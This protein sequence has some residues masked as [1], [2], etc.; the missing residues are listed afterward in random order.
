M[1]F[2]KIMIMFVL[3]IFA[4]SCVSAAENTTLDNLEMDSQI[5]MIENST[6]E[7]SQDEQIAS[8]INVTFDEKVYEKNLTD[9]TVSLPESAQGKLNVRINNHTIYDENITGR[10]VVIPIELPPVKLPVIVP[11]IW[12]AYDFTRYDVTAFY[13]GFKI[14]VTHD[15]MVMKYPKDH[16]PEFMIPSEIV[17]F[18]QH[19]SFMPA[20]LF[21]RS[22][23]GTV[24]VYLDGKILINRTNVTAPFV[25]LNET[26]ITSLDLGSHQLVADYSGDDYYNAKTITLDFNVTD[27]AISIPGNVYLDHDDCISVSVS[28][29]SKGTVAIYIDSKLVTKRSLD[30]Y[31]ELIFSL[32]DDITCGAHEI[33]VVV[34]CGTFNRTKTVNVNATYDIDL[35]SRYD[36]RYGEENT[37]YVYIPE[38][39]KEKLFNVTVNGM[40]VPFKKYTQDLEIDVSSLDVGNYT[41]VVTYLGD[42][43]YYRTTVTGNF[44]VK[45]A[46]NLH[47]HEIYFGYLTKVTLNLP[48]DAKGNLSIYIGGVLY[49]T[50]RLDK[51]KASLQISDLNPGIYDVNVTYTGDDYDVEN[52]S[53]AFI[54]YPRLKYE[55]VIEVGLKNILEFRVPKDCRG[56]IKTTIN[57]KNYTSQIRDG[58][59]TLDLSNL[60]VGDWDFDICY[61]GEDGYN[62]S[63]YA[64]VY[65]EKAPVKII[66]KSTSVGYADGVY[67][68][69]VYGNDA[70]VAKN[71]KVT[72]KIN[73]KTLKNVKTDSQGWAKVN[74]PAK[75]AVGKYTITVKCKN[76]KV[77]KS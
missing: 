46:I 4:M 47:D 10:T 71:A 29:K 60:P 20:I 11:N 57:G 77:S 74:I 42:D 45:Y 36:F 8:E 34:E 24:E 21:P 33:R 28:N 23:A 7:I 54:A 49:K 18:G 53:T 63:Y 66:A 13:N 1:R 62:S 75:Y 19:Y 17:Q 43:K 69:R 14:N 61:Y 12:P 5:E 44:S 2:R 31:G 6:P 48:G 64:G 59:A 41:V 3:L 32:F 22:A 65:V 56:I 26:Q 40:K 9:I 52:I 16:S 67:K 68:V 30:M 25:F 35:Y 76:T 27:I 55:S 73:G 72:F 58:L 37:V 70:K 51:G 39:L 15:L 50:A 38:D